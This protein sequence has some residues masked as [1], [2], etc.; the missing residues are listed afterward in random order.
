MSVEISQVVS[1]EAGLVLSREGRKLN[2]LYFPKS[3]AERKA[4]IEELALLRLKYLASISPSSGKSPF[5]RRQLDIIKTCNSKNCQVVWGLRLGV[6]ASVIAVLGLA[7]LGL[8]IKN[9]S[10]DEYKAGIATVVG[11]V[12]AALTILSFWATGFAPDASSNAFNDQQDALLE[13]EETYADLAHRLITLYY[14]P[15]REV[16][17]Q[18]VRQ[19]GMD[20]L[21][22]VISHTI[23]NHSRGQLIIARLQEGVNF[24]KSEG[25]QLPENT[26]FR[27]FIQSQ[28][29]EAMAYQSL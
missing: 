28:A 24:I 7:Y 29:R 13:M 26:L 1:V 11:G 17:I 18:L 2:K 10:S 15:Q 25:A 8:S 22:Q 12:S 21:K 9:K 19:I 6:A 14:S 23:H 20:R 27:C 5:T 3:N 16:A 4:P